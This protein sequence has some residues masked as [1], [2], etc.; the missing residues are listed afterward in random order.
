MTLRCEVT[1]W[2]IVG[3]DLAR[4]LDFITNDGEETTVQIRVTLKT[5][6]TG[7][8]EACPY[9]V[10]APAV[11]HSAETYLAVQL[12]AMDGLLESPF[13]NV[14]TTCSGPVNKFWIREGEDSAKVMEVLWAGK[15]LRWLVTD[16]REALVQMRLPHDQSFRD[17]LRQMQENLR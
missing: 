14:R 15:D 12:A 1:D 3:D 13:L 5:G 8:I 11:S 10:L 7:E 4:Q 2:Q 6:D 17:A 9:I 16:G